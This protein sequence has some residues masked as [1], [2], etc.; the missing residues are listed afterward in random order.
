[1][2]RTKD[3]KRKCHDA[4]SRQVK[5]GSHSNQEGYSENRGMEKLSTR[6]SDSSA[7]PSN[8]YSILDGPQLEVPYRIQTT[9]KENVD[10]NCPPEDDIMLLGSNKA[11]HSQYRIIKS[12]K[13]SPEEARDADQVSFK[14]SM[15]SG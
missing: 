2:E 15:Y 12:T 14:I 3:S 8:Q 9:E 10:S 4:K 1:M 11:A 6:A 7:K 13:A 5:A